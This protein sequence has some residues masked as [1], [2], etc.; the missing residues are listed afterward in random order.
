MVY[1]N[2][3]LKKSENLVAFYYHH[4]GLDEDDDSDYGSVCSFDDFQ[5][6]VHVLKDGKLVRLFLEAGYLQLTPLNDRVN[7]E[8]SSQTFF[9]LRFQTPLK[10]L[11]SLLDNGCSDVVLH[12][13]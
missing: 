12:S 4:I 2:I 9:G 13:F 8:L 11:E 1:T 6:A 7:V 10:Q 3:G 5:K